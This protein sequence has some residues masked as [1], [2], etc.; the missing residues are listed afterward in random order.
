[1][2]VRLTDKAT[3]GGTRITDSGYMVTEA[4]AVRTGVQL[5]TGDEVGRPDLSIV[6]VYRSEDEV[7]S[8]DSLR[9]FTH[10]PVTVGHPR[11]PVT[12]DNW[13][14]LAVGEVSTEATWDGNKIKLPLIVKDQAAIDG[15]QSGTRELSAGY[16][17]QL[18]W[19]PGETPD[20]QTYDARQVNIRI[21]HLAIV[22]RGRAGAECRIGDA[23]YWGAS[24]VP[25]E[26][27][28]TM[29]AVVVG[30]EVV[31]VQDTDADKVKKFISDLNTTNAKELAKKDAEIATK[32]ARIA[33]LEKSQMTDAQLD[34][35]VA[36]RAQLLADASL[37]AP[38]TDFKGLSDADIRKK[39]VLTV[40]AEY[41]DKSAAYIDAMFDIQ[42]ENAKKKKQTND[43]VLQGFV[44]QKQHHAQDSNIHD[45]GEAAREARLL[46]AW[47]TKE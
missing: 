5:Y 37:I 26:N 14:Q 36:Q 2:N 30:D 13:K 10:T 35:R 3:I 39:A 22:P 45:F 32:D 25:K 7:R 11:E 31:Q 15:I 41:A 20:G 42:L 40:N 27:T 16:I 6:R 28:M 4:F 8:P 38:K 19:T 9:T 43:N 17:C 46:D 23:D 12:S 44:S 34:A 47:K 33:E 29:K 1:M 24:P 18:D 21:N